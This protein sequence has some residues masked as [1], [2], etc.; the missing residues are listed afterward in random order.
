[1]SNFNLS[2]EV[3]S[4]AAPQVARLA[5]TGDS[6]ALRKYIDEARTCRRY[7][8]SNATCA[9]QVGVNP[10]YFKGLALGV[11]PHSTTGTRF[12][13]FF[14]CVDTLTKWKKS[15]CQDDGELKRRLEV[16]LCS[17]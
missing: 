14:E 12:S 7:T 6:D 10:S 5:A 13:S 16:L 2:Q 8:V 17:F 11:V 4:E 15:S 3:S 9:A 1:M